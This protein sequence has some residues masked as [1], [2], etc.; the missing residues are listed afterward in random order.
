VKDPDG[1]NQKA[2]ESLY[3]AEGSDWNWWYGDEHSSDSD[4]IFDF[5]FRE[6]LSNIYRFLGEEPPVKLSIPVILKDREVKPTREPVNFIHPKIDGGVS[7]YFEWMGAGFLEGR[8]HGAAMHD[9]VLL[10]KGFYFGFD[11]RSLYMRVD[12]DKSFIQNIND[13]SFE[14]TIAGKSTFE[15]AYHV[16]RGLIESPLPIKATFSDILEM[17]VDF[18]SLGVKAGDKINIWSSLKIKEMLVD[19]IP[20]RGYL[21]IKVPSE[22]FEMEM[23]YV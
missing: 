4:E 20:V 10:M 8:G 11:E 23:W 12:I 3:I 9:S 15:S 16:K 17:K 5:L 22:N 19:R 14:I 7:N 21:T 2:W 18:E 6:N 1:L 13:L